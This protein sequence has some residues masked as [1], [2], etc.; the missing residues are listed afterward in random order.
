MEKLDTKVTY[1][2]GKGWGI[3]VF[4]IGGKILDETIVDCRTKI[5]PAIRS[6]L[7]ML[8]KCGWDSKMAHNSRMRPGRKQ[9]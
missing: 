1:L 9:H 7:R 6:I 3:R 4:E 8:D 5:G 2:K